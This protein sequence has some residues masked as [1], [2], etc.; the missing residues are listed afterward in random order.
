[1]SAPV[2]SI[3]KQKY[4]RAEI[5][6]LTSRVGQKV[7]L[8][9]P[10]IDSVLENP[11][12][13]YLDRVWYGEPIHPK[14]LL[15]DIAC[16]IDSLY[17]HRYDLLVNLQLLPM[18]AGLA[19]L[20]NATASVGMTLS[21]D[22][23]P[24]TQGNVW[25]AYL[26]GVS[27]GL[28]R[29]YN[30]L[31]RTDIFCRMID[32]TG[33]YYPDPILMIPQEAMESAQRFFDEKGIRDTDVVIGLNPMAG[34]SIRQW[35]FYDR[36]AKRIRDELKAQVI[37]FGAKEEEAM[38]GEIV[39]NAGNHAIQATRFDIHELLAA[40]CGCDLFITNDTGPM[41]LACLLKRKIIALFGPTSFQE[42]GP[43]RTEFHCLQAAMCRSC[44]KQT[45]IIPERYCMRQIQVTD[46]MDVAKKVIN[47]QPIQPG[48]NHLIYHSSK[49]NPLPFDR[50]TYLSRLLLQVFNSKSKNQVFG[51]NETVGPIDGMEAS[52][53]EIRRLKALVRKTLDSLNQS[54]GLNDM[55]LEDLHRS[56]EGV[57]GFLKPIVAINALQFLD[58]RISFKQYPFGWRKFYE[59][60]EKD[61][62]TLTGI[63]KGR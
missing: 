18:S 10:H 29:P 5:S 55:G 20:T 62:V 38:V 24:L 19:K 39:C 8:G 22:G 6:F 11:L 58:R 36:L 23:M 12:D 52:F 14:N 13:S 63:M 53:E 31:H 30:S 46:V 1:M 54:S 40:I 50:N 44:Y 25:T 42:V 35:P 7:F 28:M 56:I 51:A 60:I 47:D 43:W 34:T 61:L 49:G 57:S 16:L 3:L 17:Q 15:S 21:C 45:C 41:H 2:F 59:G 32:E 27:T 37:V 48:W 9:N 4:P 33:K 26:F